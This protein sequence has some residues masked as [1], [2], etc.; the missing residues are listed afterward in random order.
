MWLQKTL[1]DQ[2]ETSLLLLAKKHQ[3]ELPE[4]L[5]I[6]IEHTKNP[7]HGDLA[8]NIALIYAKQFNLPPRKLAQIFIESFTNPDTVDKIEIAGP[9]F[10]NFYLNTSIYTKTIVDII[11]SADKFFQPNYAKNKKVYLEYISA[12][13]TGPLHVGHG[14][15]AVIG[16]ALANILS[17]AGYEVHT[18][19][20]VNNV[21][22]QIDTL[23]LSIWIQYLNQFNTKIELPKKAYQG[24]YITEIA[25]KLIDKSQKHYYQPIIDN[26]QNFVHLEK[27]TATTTDDQLELALQQ[28]KE[29]LTA[30]DINNIAQFGYEQIRQGIITDL[31]QL[32]IHMD[33]WFYE[34]DLEKNNDIKHSIQTLIDN[35]HTYEKDGNLWFK[36]TD[37][38]DEKDRVMQRSNGQHTYFAADI[39]YHWHKFQQGHDLIIDI[40]GSDHHGYIPRVKAAMT[41]LG[42]DVN[43]LQFILVQFATLCKG[44]EKIQMSTRSGQFVTLETLTTDVGADAVHYFYNQ[45]KPDQHMNFDLELAKSQ[46]QDN[47]VYYVQYAHARICSM[48]NQAQQKNMSWQQDIGIHNLNLLTD[49]AEIKL[50]QHITKYPE[51]LEKI[52]TQFEPHLLTNY[53]F[54]LAGIMH[55]YYN[56]QPCLI[57]DEKLRNARLTLYVSIK[58]II[59]RGL[60]LLSITAPEKM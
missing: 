49:E 15:G 59:K 10:I 26:K 2:I 14:R 18:E 55:S 42:C 47:P 24:N 7:E 38:G 11:Q 29:I 1:K 16:T 4:N 33:N 57:A 28:F 20:Y 9:G 39:A 21:G 52:S 40:M 58:A 56:A 36:S 32:N 34:S 8:T 31:Q 46:S 5:T 19:Y 35:G 30:N 17:A 54:E 48:L 51:V 43:K 44:N 41:A 3:V 6:T 12:N 60:S 23:A 50:M 53:L 13:P 22:K 27:I 45:R 25:K 37:F